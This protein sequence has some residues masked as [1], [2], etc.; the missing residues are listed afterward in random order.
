MTRVAVVKG[1]DPY[2]T[3]LE[4]LNL[5]ADDILVS[6]SEVLLKPNLLLTK[7]FPL[8]VTDPR[9]CAAV[10]DF[11]REQKDI[12]TIKLGEGTTGGNPPDTFESMNNNG[13]LPYQDRWQPIDFSKD[14]PGKWF[15]IYNPGNSRKLELGIAKTAIETPYLVSIPKFKTHDVLGLTLSLKNLMGTLTAARDAATKEIIDNETTRVCGY[16]HGFGNKKPDKLTDHQ[17]TGPSK[18]AL[19]IN[20]IRLASTL[21]PNLAIIDGIEAMEGD[22][23]GSHGTRKNLGMI[24]AGTDFIAVDSVASYIAGMD[25]SHFQYLYQAGLRGLGEFR[26]DLISIVG[27]SIADIRSPFHPHRLYSHAKFTEDEIATLEQNLV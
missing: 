23:P 16:M 21:L 9:V 15:P 12:I 25:L 10:A 6:Q 3:T 11:L 22:G 8:A 4:A 24:I 1:N 26:L 14:I 27:E 5:I 7:K 20:L 19:A 2:E 18:V 13:Y 17:N